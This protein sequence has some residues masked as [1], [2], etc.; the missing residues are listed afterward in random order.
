MIEASSNDLLTHSL[1]SLVEVRRHLLLKM[2]DLIKDDVDDESLLI[3]DVMEDL[4][5]DLTSFKALNADVRALAKVE[6]K[7]FSF[8]LTDKL[9]RLKNGLLLME[10]FADSQ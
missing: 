6:L 7:A 5:N 10:A 1:T 2:V 9:R 4:T 3:V 8:F